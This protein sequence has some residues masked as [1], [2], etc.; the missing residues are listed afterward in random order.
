MS[1]PDRPSQAAIR[2]RAFSLANEAMFTVALQIRRLDSKEPEDESFI[3]RWWADLQFLIVVLRRLRRVAQLAA[4]ADDAS[5]SVHS[6]I[7][8][9]D[10][11]LPGLTTMRNVGEH[12]DAYALDDPK[13]HHPYVDRR[14]LQVGRWDGRTYTWLQDKS[15]QPLRLNVDEAKAAAERLYTTIRQLAKATRPK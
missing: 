1:V 14:Q 9:F 13:R 4:E 6:A 10:A 11:E 2:E 12:I 15:E 5:H 8:V 3:F 7:E